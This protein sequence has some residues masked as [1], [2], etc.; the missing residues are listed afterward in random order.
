MWWQY[1]CDKKALIF[2]MGEWWQKNVC[3]RWTW[4]FRGEIFFPPLAVSREL[5]V[6]QCVYSRH[7]GVLIYVI[8]VAGGD[9][10]IWQNQNIS[11]NTSELRK[12]INKNEWNNILIVSIM[13]VVGF[14]NIHYLCKMANMIIT[15]FS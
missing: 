14:S 6:R 11:N 15:Y 7:V 8:R 2:K 10:L 13:W 12:K 1:N 9:K 4:C 3:R 5:S